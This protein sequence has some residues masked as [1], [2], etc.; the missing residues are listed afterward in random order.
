MKK[1]IN[2]REQIGILV[3]LQEIEIETKRI[4]SSLAGVSGKIGSLDAEL[5]EAGQKIEKEKSLID[6]LKKKYRSCES[7]YQANLSLFNKSQER[8][9]AVKTNKEYQSI[10]KEID[11]TKMKN[12]RIEEEML[13]DLDVIEDAEKEVSRLKKEFLSIEER[14]NREREILTNETEQDKTNLAALDEKWGS[15]SKNVSSE[16]MHKFNMVREQTRGIAISPVADS[17][18]SGCNMNIPPQMYN[19]LQRFDSIKFCP[20]CQR[21][22]YWGK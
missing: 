3:Q 14:I 18:C 6:E 12:S 16:L 7:D 9:S 19:E 8:L 21:I 11:D 22:I 4:K 13:K 20:H 17:I 2:M 1:M 15:I 10:L 5:S